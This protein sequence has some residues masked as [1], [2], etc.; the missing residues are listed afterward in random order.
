MATLAAFTYLS[1]YSLSDIKT[2]ENRQLVPCECFVLF[3]LVI[4]D[5]KEF[6]SP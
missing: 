6:V 4:V 3:E 1:Y 5:D 2:I